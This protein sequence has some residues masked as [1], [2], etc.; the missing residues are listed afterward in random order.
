LL[1]TKLLLFASYDSEAVVSYCFVLIK[2][3]FPKIYVLG[4]DLT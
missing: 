1:T 3:Q 4:C 2:Q